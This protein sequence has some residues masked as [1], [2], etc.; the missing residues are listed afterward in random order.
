MKPKLIIPAPECISHVYFQAQAFH[1]GKSLYE[2]RA[3]MWGEGD[4]YMLSFVQNDQGVIFAPEAGLGTL[5]Q[6]MPRLFQSSIIAA[7]RSRDMFLNV[8]GA[9]GM[10]SP[11]TLKHAK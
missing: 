1:G 2:A 9:D 6:V 7:M 10:S 8:C 5:D 11:P 3:A 4:K